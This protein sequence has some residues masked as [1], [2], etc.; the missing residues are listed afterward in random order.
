MIAATASWAGSYR[1]P[2]SAQPV[3]IVARVTGSH[4]AVSLGP[5][6]AYTQR[7]D[8]TIRGRRIRFAL[9]GSPANLVFTGTVGSGRLRGTVAQGNRKGSFS[10]RRG[11]NR[12]VELLG[13]YRGAGGREVAIT[14]ASGLSPFL[15]EFPSGA[16]HGIG[17]SLTVGRRLGDTSGFGRL[18]MDGSGFRWRGRRYTRL[19]VRQREIRVGV[20]AATLS[21][22]PGTGP[23]PAV[24][25][26]HG[27]GPTM[28]DEFDVFTAWLA[29]HGV[30]VL[31]D[32]KRGTGQSG[33]FYPGDQATSATL[34]LLAGDAQAEVAFL[35][36]LPQIDRTRVG[37]WGD[38]QGGWIS[39]LA[40]S[41]DSAVHWLVE[42]SGPTVSVGEA[43]Y[44]ASLAGESLYPPSGTFAQM[45]K[46]V[47]AQGPSGFDPTPYLRKLAVPGLWMF[48]S[49][50][51]NIPT[52]L[53]VQRLKQVKTGHDFSWNVLATAHTPLILPTG[54]LSSLPRSPGF[55][56]HFFPDISA[57]LR[58]RSIMH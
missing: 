29:L 51:R 56:Q 39:V 14:E 31:A 15:T 25:M 16:A 48:G 26:V 20:D 38:S 46:Q 2:R 28:R 41:R 3:A 37:L 50:D 32:D 23:F 24:A 1:L 57:W 36:R 58:A 21:L 9:P 12:I 10:L 47:E 18:A 49:D 33:G 54:L 34:K 27:S 4:A 5:G 42:N 40:A 35:D 55:D 7:V 44:W 11:R 52:E 6:H 30:A 53:C 19:H 43:D 8:V 22:P 13:A 17:K 45:L